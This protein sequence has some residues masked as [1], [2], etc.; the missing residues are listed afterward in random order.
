MTMDADCFLFLSIE[1]FPSTCFDRVT[2]WPPTPKQ[3][4][5]FGT[6]SLS[7]S[8]S[9]CHSFHLVDIRDYLA[10]N[11]PKS[12]PYGTISSFN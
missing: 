8:L 12:S 3:A 2:T 7:F 6:C 4:E 11:F 9:L 10:L 5:K 1:L